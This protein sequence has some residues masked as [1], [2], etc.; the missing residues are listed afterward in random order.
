MQIIDQMFELKA[1]GMQA[2]KEQ[3][4]GAAAFGAS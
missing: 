2:A 4:P 1:T 3:W